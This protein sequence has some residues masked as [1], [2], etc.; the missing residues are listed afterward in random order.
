MQ[1]EISELVIAA[2][3][4]KRVDQVHLLSALD[5]PDLEG[6]VIAAGED[7]LAI[8]AAADAVDRACVSLEGEDF[9]SLLGIPRASAFLLALIWLLVILGA[10]ALF[11]T[12][13][14]LLLDGLSRINGKIPSAVVEEGEEAIVAR[15]PYA[16][17]LDIFGE[18][19]VVEI[20][21]DVHLFSGHHCEA[22]ESLPVRAAN[23]K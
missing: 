20:G 12:A 23:G 13:V 16:I 22:G 8:R 21:H 6:P 14:K 4:A 17:D 7:A 18:S 2:L 19:L 1:Q 5:I 3:Q 15:H 11:I 9:L 10:V